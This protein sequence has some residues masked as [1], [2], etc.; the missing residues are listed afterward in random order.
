MLPL[1][2]CSK[3]PRSL[4]LVSCCAGSIP[5]RLR[6]RSR[7][8]VGLTVL[9]N[10]T[11]LVTFREPSALGGEQSRIQEPGQQTSGRNQET[12]QCPPNRFDYPA[13]PLGSRCPGCSEF[14][15][16]TLAVVYPGWMVDSAAGRLPQPNRREFGF[17]GL[18]VV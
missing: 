6:E 4:S 3:S 13:V 7:D 16:G 2:P 17:G 11:S 10:N 8:G 12:N 15:L 9:S 5:S 18:A 14:E 1:R